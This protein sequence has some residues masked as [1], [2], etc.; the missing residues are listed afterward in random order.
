MPLALRDLSQLL[1]SPTLPLLPETPQHPRV[2]LEVLT[3]AG[4]TGNLFHDDHSAA[5]CL[6]HGVDE[7]TTSD[8][9]FSRCPFSQGSESLR[10]KAPAGGISEKIQRAGA[11]LCS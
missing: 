4:V 6:E 7:L 5:L 3:A 10:L 1:A 2:F 11:N 8:R 9:D